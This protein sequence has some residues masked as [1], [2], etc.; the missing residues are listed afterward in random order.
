[1]KL[2]VVASGVVARIFR[3]IHAEAGERLDDCPGAA[4]LAEYTVGVPFPEVR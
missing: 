2:S 3:E 4:G 1:M